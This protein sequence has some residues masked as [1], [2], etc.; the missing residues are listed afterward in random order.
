MLVG[1]PSVMSEEEVSIVGSKF[2]QRRAGAGAKHI[3][4]LFTSQGSLQGI[5]ISSILKEPEGIWGRISLNYR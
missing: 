5:Q 4:S 3:I 2:H 1:K